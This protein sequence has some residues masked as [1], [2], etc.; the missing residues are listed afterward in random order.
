[1]YSASTTSAMTTPITT[2]MTGSIS[3]MNRRD[4]GL[5]LL[6]VEL[7]QAVQHL[8]QRAGR[9]ADLHHLDRDV[10]EHAAR[11]Q[12]GGEAF[13]LAHASGDLG[14]FARRGTGW[15]STGRRSPAR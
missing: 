8:L 3:V 13:T 2:R 4:F 11:E 1:M 12:R 10:R 9:F 14:D 6:V 5:D 7:C 15:S